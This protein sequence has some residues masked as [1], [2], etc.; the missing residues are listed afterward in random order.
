MYSQ[1]ERRLASVIIQAFDDS[2]TILGRLKL[3]DSFEG[4][5]LREGLSAALERKVAELLL[6][7]LHDMN[8]VRETFLE[9]IK[10]FQNGTNLKVVHA[11][12]APRVDFFMAVQQVAFQ[13]MT[14]MNNFI[15]IIRN[16]PP[17]AGA[18]FWI[19]GLLQRVEDPMRRIRRMGTIRL[20]T[21][22][23]RRVEVAYEIVTTLLKDS[24]AE[25]V[26][27][28]EAEIS[29]T[30]E[31]RLRL[32]LLI[33]DAGLGLH[34]NFDPT[35]VCM[36]RETKYFLALHMNVPEAASKIFKN[37]DTYRVYTANLEMVANMY[38]TMNRSLLNVER[39]LIL[40]HMD[41]VEQCLQK[42]MSQITWKSHSISD[43]IAQC[44][45]VVTETHGIVDSV[46]RKS[47]RNTKTHLGLV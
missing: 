28:W 29:L 44:T 33:R 16:G 37:G 13:F 38:N 40:V 10:T 24:E 9:C 27:E 35:V 21:E 1:L 7:Y 25:F 36:L 19:R 14:S 32:P 31:S 8:C 12:E 5:L 34:V 39:P 4:L 22:A 6:E 43:F 46:K 15:P 26:K 42:G 30:S 45:L 47:F 20:D 17:R 41:Q 23:F 18:I 11:A 2:T 3:L